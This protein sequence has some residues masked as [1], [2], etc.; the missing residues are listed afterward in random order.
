LRLRLITRESPLARWQTEFVRK[1]L[2][3]NHPKLEIQITAIKTQ[4]DR[5]LDKP[6]YKVGGKSL[7]VKE[8][9]QALLE[10]KA[11]VAVHSLKDVPFV[12][13]PG[14]FLS[15]ICQRDN[16]FDAWICPQGFSLNSL[17]PK[18]RVGTS[19]LRR[20]LQ[21]KQIRPDLQYEPLRGNV[22]SRLQKCQQGD[23]DA[24][25]LAV[26]GLERLNL[27]HTITAIFT[28][29]QMLPAVGQGAL[30][31]E[32]R[33]KDHATQN[34]LQPLEDKP[35]RLCVTAERA[36]SAALEGNCQVPIAGF[37]RI[38]HDQLILKALIGDP[39]EPR[40]LHALAQGSLH[41]A[42]AI[43]K[44]AAQQLIDQGALTIIQRL[45]H[46]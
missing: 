18:A 26:A 13:P 45:R 35:T 29:T 42:V 27:A 24:I 31:L 43:G 17:P 3:E 34:L 25:V 41:E 15:T 12:L 5:W 4:G 7:F 46:V 6:L 21:L 22:G 30:A 20:I 19:S 33:E 16:P 23:W 10:D 8:L 36:M 32:C 44:K 11:D 14:L 2:L 1:R 28:E 40:L 9:E 39:S 38:H 37:A